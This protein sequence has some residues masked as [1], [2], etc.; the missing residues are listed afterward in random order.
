MDEIDGTDP[1]STH[2]GLGPERA[3]VQRHLEQRFPDV[4]A[5]KVAEIID[6]AAEATAGA[7][8]QSFRPLLVEHRASD[9]L[10]K[11]R[12]GA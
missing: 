5:E 12:A 1:A 4:A 6:L 8:I 7:K 3:V 2:D 10:L 9:Q 11:I